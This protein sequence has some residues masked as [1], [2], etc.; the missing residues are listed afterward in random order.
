MEESITLS[1]LLVDIF[2]LTDFQKAAA[3]K[4]SLETVD[5][6][7]R[8]LPARYIN[9]SNLISVNDAR[10]G[11]QVTIEGKILFLDAKKTFQ[12]RLNITEARIADNTGEITA[13]WFHQPY[14]SRMLVE[15]DLVRL[16]GKISEKKGNLF[17]SNPLYEKISIL[18]YRGSGARMIPVYP[19]T[20]GLSSRWIQFHI[21]KVFQML[22]EE[23]KLNLSRASEPAP[24][25]KAE[26]KSILS[27]EVQDPIPKEI[28]D[29]YHLPDLYSAFR[30]AHFPKN[31]KE[32]EAARKRLAFEEIFFIQIMRMR[33]RLALEELSALPIPRNKKIEQEFLGRLPFTLTQTQARMLET[34]LEDISHKTPMARLLE[35]D[36]GSGKTIIAAAASYMTL[37]AGYQTTYMAPTEILARQHF[38]SFSHLMGS[39]AIKIG[40]LTSS[41]ARIYPSKAFGSQ[42][43]HIPKSQLLRW[44]ESGEVKILIGT[45]S[46]LSEKI[47]FKNLAFIVVDEQHR[48]GVRQRMR[49][50]HR[51]STE[52]EFVPHFLSM[53]ATPIPRTLALTV[54]GDLDLSVLDELPP[55]RSPITTEVLIKPELRSWEHVRKEIEKGR[56]AF[57]ICPRIDPGEDESKSV[58][59]E[60]ERMT[61]EIFP[62]FRTAMLHGKMT[63]RDKERTLNDFRVGTINILISTTVIEVGIDIPNA[64]IMIVEGADRFGLAQLHQLRGRIGRGEH[65]SYFYAVS[66]TASAKTAQRLRAL[67]DA[68][69][70]FELA[71]HDLQLRGPGELT[72][73]NQWG[74][75]DIGMEAL[76][77]IK[78]VEAA[79]SEA[80]MLL[81]Q[82]R[83][84][85]KYPT[86]QEKI[87]T[88]NQEL[89]HFE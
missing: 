34:I 69:S 23:A 36:V 84:L 71:E 63:P 12:K 81:T 85:K 62:E 52:H 44:V 40:L 51:K 82:D 45:H 50:A 80:K 57:I 15:D 74:I 39:P 14:I 1:T 41:E 22:T 25:V 7:L 72:G 26:K 58:K 79:R 8:Y 73:R 83:E 49:L 16:E 60:Y 10:I 87:A 70:G 67:R 35:G 65:K 9:T 17:I 75:S 37:H 68:S 33:E 5:D 19:T 78:M 2:R 38:D 89:Y 42:S 28:L 43:A 55:G 46:L 47:K 24:R 13:V 31:E 3:K 64:T 27:S 32:V 66:E 48:F 86:L 54:F 21:S 88:L 59:K 18:S 56:Q 53:T 11:T 77:N 6:L 76:K 29:R 61:Q 30:A 4:L 20:R